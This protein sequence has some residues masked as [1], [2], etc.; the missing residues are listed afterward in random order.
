M[1]ELHFKPLF[2]L[3]PEEEAEELFYQQQEIKRLYNLATSHYNKWQKGCTSSEAHYHR[4]NKLIQ[5][6]GGQPHAPHQPK[7]TFT[8][9]PVAAPADD[10]F[11]WEVDPSSSSWAPPSRL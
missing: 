10:W 2:Q 8:P 9:G 5:H 7:P 6:L 4:T 11:A 1:A 3:T